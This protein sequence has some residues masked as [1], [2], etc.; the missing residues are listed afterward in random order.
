LV[1]LLVS[2]RLF[3]HKAIGLFM[4]STKKP[5]SKRF[6]VLMPEWL[7]EAAKKLAEQKGITASEYIRDLIKKEAAKHGLG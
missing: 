4:T 2:I 3:T 7:E 5:K 1:L 6:Q